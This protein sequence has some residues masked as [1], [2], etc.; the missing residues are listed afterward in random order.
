MDSKFYEFASAPGQRNSSIN[1]LS[2]KLQWISRPNKHQTPYVQSMM[3]QSDITAANCSDLKPMTTV[4]N[5]GMS[6][7]YLIFPVQLKS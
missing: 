3:N 5:A 7:T 1:Y 6:W 2:K 4:K